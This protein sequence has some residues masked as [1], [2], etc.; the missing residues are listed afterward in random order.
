MIQPFIS[1]ILSIMSFILPCLGTKTFA[2]KDI[3]L[4][5]TNDCKEG[6]M[7]ERESSAI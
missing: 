1:L 2:P 7:I 5:V 6:V 4:Q 3:A